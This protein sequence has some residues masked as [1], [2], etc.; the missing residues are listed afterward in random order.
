M[1]NHL[2]DEY[3]VLME[4]VDSIPGGYQPPV[5]PFLS[6]VVNLNI[7]SEAHRDSMDKKNICMVIPIGSF[8]G[9]ELVLVEQGLV[10]EVGNG[11]V[12]VFRSGEST[13]FNL[14]YSGQ[15]AS[16]VLHTDREMVSWQKDKNFWGGNYYYH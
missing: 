5:P 14:D 6:L 12:V 8:E 3:E 16:F 9:G 4:L 2:P 13:H 7:C 1:R 15:R 10:L 11:D